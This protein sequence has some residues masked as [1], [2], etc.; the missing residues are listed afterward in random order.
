M[1]KL[2]ILIAFLTTLISQPT[3][4]AALSC[5]AG[6]SIPVVSWLM[7]HLDG[8]L[9]K[10]I[11]VTEKPLLDTI[12]NLHGVPVPWNGYL[13]PS[14]FGP[15]GYPNNGAWLDTFLL[16]SDG[17]RYELWFWHSDRLVTDRVLVFMFKDMEYRT[18]GKGQHNGQHDF[19]MANVAYKDVV[20][21]AEMAGAS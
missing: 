13:S 15:F 11:P 17:E 2:L 12:L 1:I 8:A 5:P 6:K 18:D 9:I 14:P 10:G 3:P 4:A 21:I 19:C 7:N 16:F 20:N